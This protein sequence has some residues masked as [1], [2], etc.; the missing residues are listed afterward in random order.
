MRRLLAAA[1]AAA[2]GL[3]VFPVAARAA[4]PDSTHKLAFYQP[5][6]YDRMTGNPKNLPATAPDGAA[7]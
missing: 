4:M 6:T 7:V 5:V 2:L 3:A 1:G